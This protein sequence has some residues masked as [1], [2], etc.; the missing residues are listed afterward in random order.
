MTG[1]EEIFPPVFITR[2]DQNN[3]QLQFYKERT[4]GV[5]EEKSGKITIKGYGEDQR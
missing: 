3:G 4:A 2:T 1:G 5:E